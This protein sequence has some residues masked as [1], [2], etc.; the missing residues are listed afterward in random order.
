MATPPASP[1]SPSPSPLHAFSPIGT[2]GPS[3]II[4][5]DQPWLSLLHAKGQRSNH[6]T[7]PPCQNVI[8]SA[9]L[10]PSQ[11]LFHPT[12]LLRL[13]YRPDDRTPWTRCCILALRSVNL[14]F[15]S[16]WSRRLNNTQIAFL[17]PASVDHRGPFPVQPTIPSLTFVKPFTSLG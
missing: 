9:F 6:P 7:W 2:K 16:I 11:C 10:C 15:L 4:I 1:R 8:N 5:L 17:R 3:C 14:L 12:P 13:R